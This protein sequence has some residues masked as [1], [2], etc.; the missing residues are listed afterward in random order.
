MDWLYKNSQEFNFR[1]ND[2]ITTAKN[3]SNFLCIAAIFRV[4]VIAC[5][6][7]SI[8]PIGLVFVT[9]GIIQLICGLCYVID[10]YP[11]NRYLLPEKYL[12]YEYW[13]FFAWIIPSTY[14]DLIS[15]GIQKILFYREI[16]NSKVYKLE[17]DLGLYDLQK[18]LFQNSLEIR[19]YEGLVS[20]CERRIE[21]IKQK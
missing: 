13:R 3:L 8:T 7:S 14:V 17:K 5:I 11:D 1:P 10:E 2:W 16:N 15:V 20:E 4:F 6:T 18:S 12:K 9:I 21:A 19:K